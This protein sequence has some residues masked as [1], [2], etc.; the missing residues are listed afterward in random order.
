MTRTLLFCCL[1]AANAA[2]ADDKVAPPLA[3]KAAESAPIE[4]VVLHPLFAVDYACSEHYEGQLPYLGDALGSDCIVQGGLEGGFMKAYR[5]NGTKNEDWYGWGVTVMAPVDGKVERININPV[6]NQPG[7]LGKPPASF[8]LLRRDDGTF[9]MVAHVADI[10]V[11]VG[12]TV[13]AGQPIGVVGNNGFARAPHIHV[14]A[15]RD[16]TPLQIRFD[17]RAATALRQAP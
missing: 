14:G 2:Q 7:Q 11:G 8:I 4:S 17:L 12:D 15:W 9:V 13:H 5:G 10:K 1:M 6:V 16:K 3:P